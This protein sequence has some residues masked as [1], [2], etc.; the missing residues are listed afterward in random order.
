MY[1]PIDR[2]TVKHVFFK[3]NAYEFSKRENELYFIVVVLFL[4][5]V[6]Q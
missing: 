6:K 4:N 3:S 5:I 2:M 1:Q